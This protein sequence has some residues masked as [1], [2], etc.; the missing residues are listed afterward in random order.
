MY[1]FSDSEW[2]LL[3]KYYNFYE[4]ILPIFLQDFL[5]NFM[6]I[7]RNDKQIFNETELHQL[8]IFMDI[9]YDYLF[10]NHMCDTKEQVISNEENHDENREILELKIILIELLNNFNMEKARELE[11]TEGRYES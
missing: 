5:N 2:N 3:I 11:N 4:S 10:D 6:L 9:I 1:Q 7:H 8:V